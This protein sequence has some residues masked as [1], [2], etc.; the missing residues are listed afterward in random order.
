MERRRPLRTRLRSKQLIDSE[1]IKA[2]GS[3]AKLAGD[4][5]SSLLSQHIADF[6]SP[7]RLE[8]PSHTL[9]TTSAG[10]LNRRP[11]EYPHVLLAEP[12]GEDALQGR[13]HELSR[14]NRLDA[15]FCG[16]PS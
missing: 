10:K 7:E 16:L 5:D 8:H 15:A 3:L 6:L 9:F 2:E 13:A 4:L 11:L 12:A 1:G 14:L